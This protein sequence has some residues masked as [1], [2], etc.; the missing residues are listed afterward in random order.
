MGAMPLWF[1]KDV[2]C[3]AVVRISVPRVA[4]WGKTSL[5]LLEGS[6]GGV[7]ACAGIHKRTSSNGPSTSIVSF[8]VGVLGR[9]EMRI[10]PWSPLLSVLTVGIL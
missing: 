9:V 10:Y 3:L 6:L 4:S 8:A 2:L 7:E 1:V 5:E